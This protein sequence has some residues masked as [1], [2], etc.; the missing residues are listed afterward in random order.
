M[1]PSCVTVVSLKDQPNLQVWF[2]DLGNPSSEKNKNHETLRF[3]LGKQPRHRSDPAPARDRTA[4]R[5]TRG[6]HATRRRPKDLRRGLARPGSR[7]QRGEVPR[8][9]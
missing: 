7:N 1:L 8:T 6:R 5:A 3:L 4:G 2:K 9:A